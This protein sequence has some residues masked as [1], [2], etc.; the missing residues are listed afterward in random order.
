MKRN[1][2]FP[3]KWLKAPDVDPSLVATVEAC[4]FEL[5]G[6]GADATT[7][8][9]LF[10]QGEVKPL[11]LNQTNWDSMASISGHDDSDD[12]S[13]TI[14]ELF[15]TDVHGPKGMTR[16]VRMRRPTR[17]LTPAPTPARKSPAAQAA[18]TPVD[19]GDAFEPPD[20]DEVGF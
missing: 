8:P 19:V 7:E 13:G 9:I 16:G 5:I 4:R 17:R 15:A 11:I 2:A 1:E 12:W 10:F 18:K 20:D 6:Q 14:V 3:G